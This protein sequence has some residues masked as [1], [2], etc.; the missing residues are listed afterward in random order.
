MLT[1]FILSHVV[2]SICIIIVGIIA[3]I[4]IVVLDIRLHQAITGLTIVGITATCAACAVA[5]VHQHRLD[6]LVYRLLNR[7]Q[8]RRK[9]L[10]ERL[11]DRRGESENDCL[12]IILLVV[13]VFAVLMFFVVPFVRAADPNGFEAEL[14]TLT[15]ELQPR[16]LLT[17]DELDSIRALSVTVALLLRKMETP[18]TGMSG[19]IIN[20]RIKAKRL[21]DQIQENL[22]TITVDHAGSILR[23]LPR[24]EVRR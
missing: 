12:N 18:P 10:M 22:I 23:R 3:E 9:T 11:E 1:D 21:L 6:G 20:G 4:G 17:A 5:F 19:D 2:R 13:A 15:A 7:K 14:R 16:V 8:P 24:E